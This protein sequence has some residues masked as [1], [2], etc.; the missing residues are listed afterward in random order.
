MIY[1][2]KIFYLISLSPVDELC[3]Y[4]IIKVSFDSS[5]CILPPSYNKSIQKLNYIIRLWLFCGEGL[6]MDTTYCR[7]VYIQS[8]TSYRPVI[9]ERKKQKER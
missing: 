3:K 4:L 2:D 5:R 6:A 9:E 1:K 7:N 8:C